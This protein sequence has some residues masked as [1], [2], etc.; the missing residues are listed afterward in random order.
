MQVRILPRALNMKSLIVTMGLISLGAASV[1]GQRTVG[2]APPRVVTTAST[3]VRRLLGDSLFAAA[4]TLEIG[5]TEFDSATTPDCD[6]SCLWPWMVPYYVVFF[7]FHPTADT[8]RDGLIVVAIDSGGETIPGFPPYGA[9]ACAIQADR[10]RFPVSRDS[11]VAL[12]KAVKFPAG[13]QPWTL[14]FVWSAHPNVG[15]CRPCDAHFD[16]LDVEP[17]QYV[18]FISTQT[19]AKL[20]GPWSG[21]RLWI[22]ATNGAIVGRHPWMAEQ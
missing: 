9:P 1:R 15:D 22:D 18:W 12:A 6:R 13:M 2:H 21:E 20:G 10:C 17:A 3:T 16:W 5:L 8:L 14:R 11:A 7:R 19:S 4:T